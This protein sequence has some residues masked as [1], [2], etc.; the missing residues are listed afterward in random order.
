MCVCVCVFN[1]TRGAQGADLDLRAEMRHHL[2][3]ILPTE[4]RHFRSYNPVRGKDRQKEGGCLFT[5]S[6]LTAWGGWF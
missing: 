5:L 1:E 2:T 6:E 3:I 4:T